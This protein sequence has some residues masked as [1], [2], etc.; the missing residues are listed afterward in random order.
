MNRNAAA[1]A[2]PGWQIAVEVDS[3]LEADLAVHMLATSGVEAVRVQQ[4]PS[5]H[6]V[7]VAADDN[8]RAGEILD[9]D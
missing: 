9:V 1:T 2:P 4:S 5:S 8:E 6:A 3:R 7:F